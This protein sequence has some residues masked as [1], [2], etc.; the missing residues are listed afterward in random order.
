MKNVKL[1]CNL[2]FNLIIKNT[3]LFELFLKFTRLSVYGFVYVSIPKRPEE[4]SRSPQGVV[5]SS[6]EH[7]VLRTK[8]SHEQ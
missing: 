1:I 2:S 6:G 3:R 4:G 8:F 5:S 7:W